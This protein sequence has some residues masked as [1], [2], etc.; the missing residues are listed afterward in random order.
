MST[1]DVST[2]SANGETRAS[3]LDL[4][5]EVVVIP[6]ADPDRSKAFYETLTSRPRATPSPASVCRSA[7][8]SIRA[9]P[10][11]SSP[12]TAQRM[13]GARDENWP[14]WYAAH[15]VAEQAGT[16]LPT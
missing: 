1:T 14:D 12:R 9:H 7:R 4:K 13:G 10:A 6:V 15:M 2:Q 5:L 16:E 3:D 8:C 11:R